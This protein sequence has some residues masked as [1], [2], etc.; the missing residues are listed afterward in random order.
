MITGYC[1][2]HCVA[3]FS[4]A[5]TI[6]SRGVTATSIWKAGLSAPSITKQP[7]YSTVTGDEGRDMFVGLVVIDSKGLI[8][9]ELRNFPL[10]MELRHSAGD[11]AREAV[12]DGVEDLAAGRSSATQT[13][14]SVMAKD[15]F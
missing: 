9:P 12:D 13:K 10:T 2:M 7:R 15:I 14:A 4:T 11:N 3:H 8:P 6:P 5:L 1:A